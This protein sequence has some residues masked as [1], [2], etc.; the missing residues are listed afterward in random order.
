MVPTSSM[1]LAFVGRHAATPRLH[2]YVYVYA[3]RAPLAPPTCISRPRGIHRGLTPN[4]PT[5]HVRSGG[6]RPGMAGHLARRSATIEDAPG[7][8]VRAQKSPDLPVD[9]LALASTAIG[10]RAARSA[11]PSKLLARAPPNGLPADGPASS[12]AAS[13]LGLKIGEEAA[14]IAL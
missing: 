11:P 2:V 14:T 6:A 12:Q 10:G 5:L 3:S 13:V 4:V 8:C 9:P 7:P 1:S